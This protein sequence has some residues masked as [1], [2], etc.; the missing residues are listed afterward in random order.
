MHARRTT[1]LL[2]IALLAAGCVAVPHGPDP[3]PPARPGALA[4]AADRPPAPLP[5]WPVP[6]EPAPREA[7]TAAEPRPDSRPDPGPARTPGPRAAGAAA[8][9]P[10]A[11]RPRAQRPVRPVPNRPRTGANEPGKP[12]VR[13]TGPRAVPR[14]PQKKRPAPVRP[15]RSTD[16]RPPEMRRLCRQAESIQA[17]MG[18]AGLCRT[19][20]G[21]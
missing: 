8:G 11:R 19:L 1:S 10:A 6:T 7:L 20:Y 14:S 5:A 16:A 13:R 12:T 18:A 4:P 17:P 3:A 9:E 21:R 2:L 15:H